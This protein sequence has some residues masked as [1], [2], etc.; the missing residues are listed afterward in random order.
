[1]SQQ[2]AEIILSVAQGTFPLRRYPLQQRERL[3]AWDTADE[4]LL[5]TL[6][7]RSLPCDGS[8]LL[9][10]NDS[11]G[12]LAVALSQYHPYSLSDS[13]LCHTATR[14]NLRDNGMPE[15]TVRLLDPFSLPE[16]QLDLVLIKVPKTLAL[17]EDELLRLAPLLGPQTQIIVAGMVR[18]M[19]SS[20]WKLLERLVGSTSTS[21]ARKKAKLIEVTAC[22]L[23][24]QP[25]GR[26]PVCYTLEG[27]KHRLCNHASVFSRERL[28]IGTRLFLQHLPQGL[29]EKVVV[30]LGCGNGVV[31]LITAERNPQASLYFVDESF[32]AVASARENFHYNLGEGRKATFYVADALSD[33]ERQSA[34]LI[35]CNPPF[36]QGSVVGDHI[37]LR[38]FRQSRQ[39]LRR[40]GE[41]WVIGNRHLGYHRVLRRLFG[42]C[43]V[44]AAN[45]KFVILRSHT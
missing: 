16:E 22:R 38:M 4:Y 28:D 2:D 12:A 30:D 6:A 26:F 20:L 3:R 7:E 35:L 34:D 11:F 27:T 25:Q 29:G 37:A 32:M 5:N 33:F 39:V 10:V 24:A 1:M 42:N 9:I 44:V 23:S 31:G 15:Q 45:A 36:H 14:Q 41:L 43:E 17:L 18:A 8:R 40:G 13:W 19:P 21:L